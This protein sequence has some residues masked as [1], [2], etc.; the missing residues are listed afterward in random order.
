M[1]ATEAE[2]ASHEEHDGNISGQ[3][4]SLIPIT[5]FYQS[6]ESDLESSGGQPQRDE[7]RRDDPN[8]GNRRNSAPPHVV[9]LTD[10]YTS[11]TDSLQAFKGAI[12]HSIFY[13]AAG[14]LAYS[15]VFEKWPIV[16]SLYFAVVL[17]TTVGYGDLHPNTP[18]GE[19]FTLI[20][21]IYGIVI[22][23]VLLGIVGEMAFQRRQNLHQKSMG[24]V[25]RKYM[26]IFT[27][28]SSF[29]SEDV[30][31]A[32]EKVSF[33][34]AALW[35]CRAQAPAFAVLCAI[36]TPVVLLE[37]WTFVKGLY[38]GVITGTTIGLGDETPQRELSRAICVLFVPLA[39]AFTGRT[40][41]LIAGAYV[42][43]KCRAV[44][45]EFLSRT[46]TIGDLNEMDIDSDG[47]VSSGEFLV[48]MLLT[49][50]KCKREDV[51]DILTR[52]S[53]RYGLLS[54][55][56]DLGFLIL[57]SALSVHHQCSISLTRYVA[58]DV[59][60]SFVYTRE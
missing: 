41:S 24:E 46:L 54:A 16:D 60:F 53:L 15:V 49:L 42:Y 29:E 33:F 47:V 37:Q 20:F 50:Q 19:I 43:N 28:S 27:H 34:A 51:E 35:I 52:K 26:E 5:S 6:I 30:V 18:G 10:E 38:W 14:T 7:T 31:E 39:A 12:F 2:V 11:W 40:L 25:R 13:L 3:S 48:F 56:V 58:R 21:A 17:F 9:G 22:V 57:G 4:R 55:P 45:E 23:G 44:E 32:K 59:C 36:A 8:H 1:V